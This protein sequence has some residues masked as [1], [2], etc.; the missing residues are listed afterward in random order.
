MLRLFLYRFI[1]TF[2]EPYK[3][4]RYNKLNEFISNKD[5]IDFIMLKKK[6]QSLWRS[7]LN[8]IVH[9]NNYTLK[10]L[11]IIKTDNYVMLLSKFHHSFSFIDSSVEHTCKEEIEYLFIIKDMKIL[12]MCNKEESPIEYDSLARN[13]PSEKDILIRLKNNLPIQLWYKNVRDI[14]L[15]YEKF[16]DNT[17]DINRDNNVQSNFSLDKKKMIEYAQQ[18]A[19]IPNK[20]YKNFDSDGG[21]CTNFI[22]Q[23]LHFGGLPLSLTWKPYTTTWIRVNEL[24]YFLLENGFRKT[25]SSL[26]TQPA[27]IIQFHSIKKGFFSH[28]GIITETFPD[29]NCL[30]CCHSFNKLNYPLSEVYPLIYD[31]IRIINI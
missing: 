28:S 7:K 18:Y 11:K 1:N 14:N 5:L 9:K 15:F 8:T 17:L 3:N 20:A 10:K 2:K 21:D 16:L 6:F 13:F 26:H 4:G 22:S 29:G 27:A 12:Y 25:S 23:C 19:L 30:Y 31:K 24:Y